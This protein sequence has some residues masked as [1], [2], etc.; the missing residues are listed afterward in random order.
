MVIP[1]TPRRILQE[2]NSQ[3]QTIAAMP[4]PFKGRKPRALQNVSK[5][6]HSRLPKTQMTLK[7]R[8]CFNSPIKVDH[9]YGVSKTNDRNG[10]SPTRSKGSSRTSI[11][12]GSS[13]GDS[14][15]TESSK[16]PLPSQSGI[17]PPSFGVQPRRR[18][19]S[20]SSSVSSTSSAL[21]LQSNDL[22][23]TFVVS[24]GSSSDISSIPTVCARKVPTSRASL[25]PV[26]G[27]SALSKPTFTKPKGRPQPVKA[28]PQPGTNSRKAPPTPIDPLKSTR[29]LGSTP[30]RRPSGTSTERCDKVEKQYFNRAQPV[31]RAVT[32]SRAKKPE[33]PLTPRRRGSAT[34]RD[35]ST[36]PPTP[37][38]RRNSSAIAAG[39]TN[40]AG[41]AKGKNVPRPSTP[42][43]EPCVSSDTVTPP[44]PV[45][46][47]VVKRK[48]LSASGQKRRSLLPTP[49]SSRITRSQS[50]KSRPNSINYEVVGAVPFNIS[51]SAEVKPRTAVVSKSQASLSLESS[52]AT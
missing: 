32:P 15:F 26:N 44:N 42:A 39:T 47:K 14:S 21:S 46:S 16:L 23:G 36:K 43:Q 9:I 40:R 50:Q 10:T 3:N 8:S 7:T 18:R 41:P 35:S 34:P 30:G 4:S 2:S 27:T 24:K 6:T 11:G 28:L 22:N 49:V 38:R 1:S 48:S 19:S 13:K 5:F 33:V 29:V 37:V 25:K 12:R 20:S 52:S 17:R 31:K 45:P 51:P